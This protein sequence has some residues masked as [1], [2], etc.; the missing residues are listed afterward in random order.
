MVLPSLN[1]VGPTNNLLSYFVVGWAEVFLI[2]CPVP[3]RIVKQ[4]GRGPPSS[5]VGSLEAGIERTFDVV[6]V[7]DCGCG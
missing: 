6:Q 4:A 3:I 5:R 2:R 1:P 7:V